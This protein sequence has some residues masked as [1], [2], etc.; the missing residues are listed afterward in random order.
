VGK[1]KITIWKLIERKK[2]LKL[3]D[4]DWSH[5]NDFKDQRKITIYKI[6]RALGLRSGRNWF[7]KWSNQL[8]WG[9]RIGNSDFS[10]D[11]KS[12][13]AV[14]GASIFHWPFPKI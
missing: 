2:G 8:I 4:E 14:R 11:S 3:N 12:R 10:D 6:W 9:K 7:W 13:K 1:T 5:K